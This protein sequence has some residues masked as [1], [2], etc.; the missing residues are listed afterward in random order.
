MATTLESIMGAGGPS[1]SKAALIIGHGTFFPED[2]VDGGTQA[3]TT[4]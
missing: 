2:G 3:A 1:V 4:R